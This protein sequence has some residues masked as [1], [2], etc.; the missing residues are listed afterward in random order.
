MA[1]DKVRY[2]GHPIAA[3]AATSNSIAEEAL[4]LIKVEY[5][6]LP[7]ILDVMEAVKADSPLIDEKLRTNDDPSLPASN[8]AK[9]NIFKS[10]NIEKGFEEADVVLEKEFDSG[11]V[12]QGYIEPHACVARF[13]EGGEIL[14]WVSSQGHFSL[15]DQSAQLLGLEP[16]QIKAIAAEIGGGFGGKTKVYLEPL[17]IL[18]SKLTGQPVKMV[19]SR[20]EVFR[21]TGPG[22]GSHTRIKMGVTK[23]GQITAVDCNIWMEAGAFPG[24]AFGA[25]FWGR[26]FP[27]ILGK[28]SRPQAK[29]IKKIINVFHT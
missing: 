26:L 13:T 18:M 17:A 9:T 14:L 11:T 8:I 3:V 15:R 25:A 24:S 19:M 4:K 27:A 23:E 22:P 6:P 20:E 29:K 1:Y 7:V 12:H 2:H 16:S 21:A 28:K 10:G 5:E